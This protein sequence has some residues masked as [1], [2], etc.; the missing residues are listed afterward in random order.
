MS[1]FSFMAPSGL[2]SLGSYSETP[3]GT[4]DFTPLLT[5]GAFGPGCSVKAL[6][7][8][9][10]GQRAERSEKTGVWGRIPQE[11]R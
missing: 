11:A 4:L 2:G 6:M 5:G 7:E 8:L 3:P 1:S 10:Q 9:Y